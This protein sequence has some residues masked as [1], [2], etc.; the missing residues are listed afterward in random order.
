MA[1]KCVYY[2]A[3]RFTPRPAHAWRACVLRACGAEVGSGCHVYPTVAI[4]APWNL[5]LGDQVGIGDG[6]NCYNLAPISIGSH[7]VISQRVHLCAGTHDYNDPGMQ[8]IASPITIE[9]NVW[10][11]A[12]AFVGPGLTIR[13]GAVIGARAVVT[14]DMPAWTVSA[15]NPARPIKARR[16]RSIG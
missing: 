7:S 3:F 9:D 2:L 11:A 13:M 15:G 8:L 5:K 6:A 4:W 14:K 16:L 1:W 12:E 10:V